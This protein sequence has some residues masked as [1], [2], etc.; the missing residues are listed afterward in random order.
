MR[1]T[2]VLRTALAV[3]AVSALTAGCLS[4]G[5]DSNSAGGA[6]AEDDKTIEIWT[7]MDQPVVD[8]LKAALEPKAKA[9]GITVTWSKVD[10]INQLI[11]TKVQ[12]NAAPDIAMIPQPGVVADLVSRKAMVP[13]DDAL[14]MAALTAS[15]VPGTLDAGTVDGKL[16]GLLTS[17]NVKSLVFY[18]KKAWEAKGWPIP[19]TIDELNALTEKIKSEGE[20]PWCLGIESA[21]ATGW[22]ATDW[23]EDLVMRYGTVDDYNKWVKG[24][25]KFDSE[26]VRK[27]AAEFETIAFTEG[28]V[29]GGRKSIASNNFGTAGNPM[30]DDKPG[31]YMYKQ[32]S[33]ITG[34]FPKDIQ[35]ALQAE[36]GVFG[37]PPVTVDNNPVLGGGDLAGLFVDTASGREVM[38]MLSATDIGTE[39]AGNGSSF[40][41]PHKDF[42]LAAYPLETTKLVAGVAYKATAFLFDG[43]DSMPGEV[44]AGTF[45]KEMTSWIADEESL[46]DALKNID[47][48]W[49]AS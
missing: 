42:P 20:T 26:L 15:M 11:V 33:F 27:A 22:P 10:N 48:S 18:P 44:G 45:W 46:D 31:C 38:K 24:E 23:F 40:I 36:V 25:I 34:F 5:T 28:N 8:G 6:S 9:A 39:A 32:G 37:F 41:S 16:Y 21:A 47:A 3:T 13:L 35:A 12:A 14:D 43:S 2:A 30:F 49:P 17:M 29:L 7:S 1:G 19:T 4:S